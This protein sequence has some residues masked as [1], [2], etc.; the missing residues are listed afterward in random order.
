MD[1][2]TIVDVQLFEERVV[3]IGA[4][5]TVSVQV[6]LVDVRDEAKGIS[7]DACPNR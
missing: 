3:E 7:Q 6:E 4:N 5:L 2:L 1:D